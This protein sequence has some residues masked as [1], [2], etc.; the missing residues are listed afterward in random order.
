MLT[1][2]CGDRTGAILQIFTTPLTRSYS[3]VHRRKYSD[4]L[5]ICRENIWED[6]SPQYAVGSDIPCHL[7]CPPRWYLLSLTGWLV[8]DVSGNR[9]RK[10]SIYSERGAARWVVRL[11]LSLSLLSAECWVSDSRWLNVLCITQNI[12]C[13]SRPTLSYFTDTTLYTIQVPGSS[14][15]FHD[16]YREPGLAI[17]YISSQ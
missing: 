6:I 10:W 15:S 12:I 13:C 9:S 2:R 8:S 17:L 11:W 16:F 5:T 14:I 3:N 7:K 1:V 4:K